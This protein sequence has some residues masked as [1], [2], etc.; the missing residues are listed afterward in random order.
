[1]RPYLR[2]HDHDAVDALAAG[3]ELG[4]GDHRAAAAG[5]AAVAAALL[6]GLEARRALDPLRLGD[7][8]GLLARLAHAHRR[9]RRVLALA[10]R[11][12][13]AAAGAAAGGARG[14]VVG[15]PA[16]PRLAWFWAAR[17]IASGDGVG[18]S[19][20]WNSSGAIEP[21]PAAA[22]CGGVAAG[23]ASPGRWMLRPRARRRPSSSCRRCASPG[24]R[25]RHPEP[26]RARSLLAAFTWVAALFAAVT[27]LRSPRLGFSAGDS[28]PA[29]P[30]S[31]L[32]EFSEPVSFT[33]AGALL[34]RTMA[35]P[36]RV[37][38]CATPREA[39]QIL[40]FA[41]CHGAARI[42]RFAILRFGTGCPTR[43]ARVVCSVRSWPGSFARERA[44]SSCLWCRRERGS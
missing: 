44:R 29:E 40:W 24:P 32:V 23:A 12:A 8:L 26:R 34:V 15:S 6:L 5:I 13:R 39:P 21:R 36:C 33:I 41:P 14:V 1:M 35:A 37:L 38:S 18:R 42:S 27:R 4:L 11:V 43:A 17:A 25:P 30:I 22:A 28:E 16:L 7:R 19:G 31:S 2:A 20:A 9:V 3:E 10:R